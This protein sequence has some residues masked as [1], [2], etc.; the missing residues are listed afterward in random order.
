MKAVWLEKLC[1]KKRSEIERVCENRRDLFRFLVEHSKNEMFIFIVGLAYPLLNE[2]VGSVIC[3]AFKK[4]VTFIRF[5]PDNFR[6]ND[7][8]ANVMMDERLKLLKEEIKNQMKTIPTKNPTI[9]LLYYDNP[10]AQKFLNGNKYF[11]KHGFINI[12]IHNLQ[13]VVLMQSRVLVK[14]SVNRI[15]ESDRS[16]EESVLSQETSVLL[17][18]LVSFLFTLGQ[19]KKVVYL[20]CKTTVYVVVGLVKFY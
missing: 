4:P 9:K 14:R 7:E 11:I 16:A 2:Q 20:L 12:I 5:N 18:E 1:L 3:T 19:H 6:V 15:W 10:C 13:S 8:V 17:S